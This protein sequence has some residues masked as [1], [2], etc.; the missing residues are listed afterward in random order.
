MALYISSLSL[1]WLRYP[2]TSDPSTNLEASSVEFAF[3]APGTNPV[4]GDWKAGSWETIDGELMARCR[5]GPSGVITLTAGRYKVWLRVNTGGER[6][7]EV[8]DTLYV[9]QNLNGWPTVFDL[10]TL[11]GFDHP[12]DQNDKAQAALD[13]AKARV[14]E[15]THQKIEAVTNDTV[16]MNI[17]FGWKMFLPE[18]PVTAVSSVTVDG[19]LVAPSEYRWDSETGIVERISGGPWYRGTRWFEGVSVV[20]SHG[21]TTI[22]YAVRDVV[23][24]VAA[25]L[26]Q[27]PSSGLTDEEKKQLA[28]YKRYLVG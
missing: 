6:P 15:Y 4:E 20:Y 21:Y 23:L 5:V 9:D 2:V 19:T 16:V 17:P 26:M 25:R 24:T 27:E 7:V 10:E 8:V 18:V 13:S 22:P 14:Q 1:E 11:V 12:S 28:P 3:K